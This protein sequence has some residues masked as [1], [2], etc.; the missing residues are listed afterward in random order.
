MTRF[1]GA[2]LVAGVCLFAAPAA[3]QI[4]GHPI[5]VSGHAGYFKSDDRARR[6][7]APEYGGAVGWRLHP[8]LS[9][10][11]QAL[12]APSKAD[13]SPEQKYNFS[14]AGIDLRF[15]LAPAE[16][17]V[18]PFVLTGAGYG[19]SHTT[20]T[21]PDKLDR[22]AGSLGLGALWNVLNQRTY[23]RA[24]ARNT[25]FRERGVQEFSNHV[26]FSVGL[27]YNFG[28]REKDTDIDGVR[29]WIDKCPDTPLGATVDA[30]GC[31]IDTDRDAIWD[32]LDQCPGTIPGCVVDSLGCA[33]DSDGDGVCDGL[34][35]CAGTPAGAAVDSL[36]CPSDTDADSVLTGIDK[37]PD[38]PVGCSV[39]AT[40]CTV[41]S[42][43]DGVCDGLDLCPATPPGTAINERGCPYELSLIE[44]TLIG[45][46]T[47]RIRNVG[48]ASARGEL[49]AQVLPALDTLATIMPQYPHLRFE[50]VGFTD[51]RGDT[52]AAYRMS[53][54]RGRAVQNYLVQQKKISTDQINSLG[55]GPAGSGDQARYVEVRVINRDGL[56]GELEKRVPPARTDAPPPPP[57]GTRDKP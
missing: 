24:Q 39:D 7:D 53:L 40:G 43:G 41:D 48:F 28:G 49:E 23:V 18:V 45:T 55:G 15:N 9:L 50:F 42:D 10:E 31:P 46:G 52:A 16:N 22:G 51:F 36:G 6:Q 44:R 21:P 13:T 26:S 14:Y 57:E 12:F 35:Q 2:L 25:F 4:V 1:Q 27:Q 17:R 56:A 47:Y 3:G 11:G 32:G 5:E 37:C 38:T 30:S 8:W 33:V 19:L 20:G 54:A 34:D 29:D